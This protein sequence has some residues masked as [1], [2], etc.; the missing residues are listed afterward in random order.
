MGAALVGGLLAAEWEPSDLAVVERMP[1]RAAQ[2][3]GLFPGVTIVDEVGPVEAVLVA[4]KPHDVPKALDAAVHAGATRILS[5]AA[6][7]SL[8]TM[9]DICGSGVAVVRAMPNTPA[10]VGKGASAVAA[11]PDT[12]EADL[13]WAE[14]ILG[15]VG[16]VERV[17]EPQ[18]EVVTSLAGSGPAF[19]FLV[20][21]ALVDGGVA[22]GLPRVVAEALVRQLYLGSAAL[23]SE[24]GRDA[25]TL[26]GEV[27]SP[28]GVTAAGLRVLE[29]N[30]V[31]SSFLE[32]VLAGAE[33]SREL[34]GSRRAP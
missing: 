4:V 26:R 31:R 1:A 22:A 8:S 27:T 9:T 33:R 21:E 20:A 34:D 30:S 17:T 23:L 16:T 2:L 25:A 12:A 15:A 6:G 14:Q 11:G 10:L 13:E 28:G 24:A 32:A 3:A 18:L 7:V 29:S 5:I 19:L